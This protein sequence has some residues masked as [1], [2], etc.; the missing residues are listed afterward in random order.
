MSLRQECVCV[1]HGLMIE[2]L[3]IYTTTLGTMCGYY[4][5]YKW[6]L[7]NT[8][9]TCN[10]SN[11]RNHIKSIQQPPP[12]HKKFLFQKFSNKNKQKFLVRYEKCFCN[13]NKSVFFFFL[14]FMYI[15]FMGVK[16]GISGFWLQI[17]YKCNTL[18]NI[19]MYVLLV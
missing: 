16:I 11:N 18:T 3:D 8:R 12:H 6:I 7:K 2:W 10:S 1:W 17:L 5:Y 19:S 4:T 15:F 9:K 13:L 14:D